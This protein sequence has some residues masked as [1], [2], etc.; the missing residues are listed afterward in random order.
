MPVYPRWTALV[1]FLGLCL[2]HW[3]RLSFGL[4]QKL[5]EISDAEPKSVHVDSQ[6]SESLSPE[7]LH[8]SPDTPTSSISPSTTKRPGWK[9]VGFK[10][11]GPP[12][13]GP[14]PK[15]VYRSGKLSPDEIKARGGIYEGTGKPSTNENHGFS[16]WAHHCELFTDPDTG[17]YGC[18][19]AGL[20]PDR[21][22]KRKTYTAYTATSRAFG[23]S[24]GFA[25]TGGP[26]WVYKIQATPNMI[27][28]DGTLLDYRF[29]ENEYEFVALGGVHY[30]QILGS[31]PVPG[32]LTTQ[33]FIEGS[34][35]RACIVNVTTEMFMKK[36]P[37]RKFTANPDYDPKFDNFEASPGQPQL[38]GWLDKAKV[39][40]N[41]E[42]WS[43]Y[44]NSNKTL[45]DFAREFMDN[46]SDEAKAAVGWN[47]TFPLKFKTYPDHRG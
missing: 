46:M 42:P 21:Y 8:E 4:D 11:K 30:G 2:L 25:T 28:V 20:A 18:D 3:P 15:I 38:A 23:T 17:E 16:I 44:Q 14:P 45:E 26:G 32:G 27:D 33:D 5:G 7:K 9:D 24:L 36:F 41:V 31:I 1:L 19:F 40:N 22:P 35:C 47:G 13:L 39:L 34:N 37:D 12:P 29:Y 6:S 43:K 10:P